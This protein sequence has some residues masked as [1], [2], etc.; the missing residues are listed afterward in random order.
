MVHELVVYPDDRIVICGPVR[1]FSDPSLPKLLD[2]MKDTMEANNLNA[3]SAIQIARPFNIVV[4]KQK[5][6]SYLEL[7]N[8]SIIGTEGERFESTE[9]TSYFPDITFKIPRFEKIKLIYEDRDGNMQSMLVEDKEL[10]ATIQRKLDFLG[11]A[12]P[13]FRLDQNQREKV[14]QALKDKGVYCAEEV[15]PVFSKKDYITSFNDKLIF[16]MGLSL[17]SPLAAKFF[18]WSSSTI[19]T[20]WSFD[21]FA[22]IATW[23]LMVVYFVYAQ[24]EAKKYRQCSSCQIGNQIGIILK[25]LVVASV[26]FGLA[27]FIVKP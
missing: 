15:C 3:L 21:K 26:I 1:S 7:I 17:L 25:R 27:L 12:T 6:G 10:S 8:P 23:I 2:D 19:A 22:Y 16:L 4:I 14:I 20:I 18:N 9:T 13:L 11:G 5:D 24:Y